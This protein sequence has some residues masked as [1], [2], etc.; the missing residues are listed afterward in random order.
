[1][2]VKCRTWQTIDYFILRGHPGYTS[3]KSHLEWESIPMPR[4]LPHHRHHQLEQHH[5]PHQQHLKIVKKKIK[6]GKHSS[7]LKDIELSSKLLTKLYYLLWFPFTIFVNSMS[8]WVCNTF[9]A[10]H[11][12]SKENLKEENSAEAASFPL[13]IVNN[14]IAIWKLQCNDIHFKIRRLKKKHYIRGRCLLKYF[15]AF[16][17]KGKMSQIQQSLC[18][19]NLFKSIVFREIYHDC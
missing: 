11:V 6:D 10:F 19:N 13:E 17:S 4:F 2:Q 5:H 15:L 16:I 12:L 1:M 9:S 7:A 8:K 3:R 14:F 18:L